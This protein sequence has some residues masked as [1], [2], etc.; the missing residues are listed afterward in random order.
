M[1]LRQDFPNSGLAD[2]DEATLDLPGLLL[3]VE[4][5]EEEDGRVPGAMDEDESS[6]AGLYLAIASMDNLD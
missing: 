3:V 1:Q 2:H 6:L 4:S 5:R